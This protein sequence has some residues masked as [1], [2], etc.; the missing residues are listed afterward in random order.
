MHPRGNQYV[1]HE[2]Y[3]TLCRSVLRMLGLGTKL[4][5]RW[6]RPIRRH[7]H[8]G[9]KFQP[10]RCD[11]SCWHCNATGKHSHS[12]RWDCNATRWQ[13]ESSNNSEHAV[14]SRHYAK[15][16]HPGDDPARQHNTR[17]NGPEWNS[18]RNNISEHYGSED[19][20]AEWPKSVDH[21]PKLTHTRNYRAA[22]LWFE[23]KSEW[24]HAATTT[25][26]KQHSTT[27][28]FAKAV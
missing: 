27:V 5:F 10:G 17:H 15:Y 19:D 18:S 21:Q 14:D 25:D 12:A 7:R 1:D 9:T 2:T 20:N 4:A 16:D 8:C 13:H 6:N 26:W 28:N 24:R 22:S 23:S 3:T 11:T